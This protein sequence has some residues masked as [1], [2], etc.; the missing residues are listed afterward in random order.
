M[1]QRHTFRYLA[2]LASLLL[3]LAG[4]LALALPAGS[5]GPGNQAYLPLIA[6]PA[7]DTIEYNELIRFNLDHINAPEGWGPLCTFTP[8]VVAVVD[9]GVDLDHPE[10]AANLTAGQSFVSGAST[11][12]DDHGHGSHVAGIVAAVANNGFGGVVGVAPRATVMPVKVLN[13]VGSGSTLDVANG[14]T[15]AVDNGATVINLSLGTVQYSATLEDAIEYA[16][17]QG[18]VVV[19]A[20]GNCGDGDYPFNGCDFQDQPAYPALWPEVIAVGATTASMN[21]ASFSTSGD[22]VEVVAPGQG[23]LSTFAFG[24]YALISG[25][26]QAAPHVAGLAALIW[27]QHPGF[28]ADQVR[29]AISGT[30]LDLGA[31]GHDEA[32]G[33]GLIQVPGAVQLDDP[34][35]VPIPSGVGQDGCSG[36]RLCLGPDEPAAGV[37]LSGVGQDEQEGGGAYLPG[38][39][40]IKVTPGADGAAVVAGAGLRVGWQLEETT[41]ARQLYRLRIPAG[42][43]WE[44]IAQLS[45][46]P[47]LEYAE[48]NY[49]V[50]GW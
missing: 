47:G 24:E 31:A 23:I 12:D 25:T 20:A 32:F 7:C 48:P 46:R 10:L 3:A 44:V 28:T 29:W 4:G 42:T 8:V 38:E 43:E 39:V 6:K 21:Q 18:A 14:I 11:P 36:W 33:Y 16:A 1:I 41:S 30:A 26:S 45:G 5:V 17:D 35:P 49:V 50:W 2:G 40:I 37:V 19:G 9:T 13:A 27:S 15:W 22:Y 34:A